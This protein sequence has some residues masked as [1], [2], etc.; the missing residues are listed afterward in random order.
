M[1]N[2]SGFGVGLALLGFALVASA[3]DRGSG[4]FRKGEMRRVWFRGRE[5]LP[6][7]RIQA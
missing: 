2:A 3:T 7:E 4:H 5:R 6:S 1:R